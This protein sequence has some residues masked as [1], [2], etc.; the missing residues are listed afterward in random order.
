M[1]LYMKKVAVFFDTNVLYSFRR[2]KLP[3]DDDNFKFI[4][5]LKKKNI[6]DLFVSEVVIDELH[7][8]WVEDHNE[9]V[10][11]L[12]SKIKE[13]K[14]LLSERSDI[15]QENLPSSLDS[16]LNS[17][18]LPVYSVIESNFRKSNVRILPLPDV[19][20]R[21]VYERDIKERKPFKKDGKGF[22]DFLIWKTLCE[23]LEKT[24][25]F[26]CDVFFI[27][28]NSEDFRDAES[29]CLHGDFVADLPEGYRVELVE[30]IPKLLKHD[31]IKSRISYF[32][33]FRDLKITLCIL[34]TI[35][36]L[37]CEPISTFDETCPGDL[38]SNPISFPGIE[39]EFID[40]EIISSSVKHNCCQISLLYKDDFII[41]ASVEVKCVI[42]GFM[43]K[44]DYYMYHEKDVDIY[45]DDWSANLMIVQQARHLRF[46]LSGNFLEDSNG[47]ETDCELSIVEVED[48]TEQ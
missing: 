6:V 8:L 30:S 42:E 3:I 14:R 39:G 13:F 21:E 17:T 5:D 19:S 20:L 16:I 31:F 28:N 23:T 37:L 10:E 24:D 36:E 38:P 43:E 40:L 41:K 48:I 2:G 15:K 26:C 33:D 1:L 18:Y 12:G 45:D 35:N 34:N 44:S 47:Q 29:S 11:T 7:R 22:R 25:E 32:D 46:G 9:I 4:S 27:T